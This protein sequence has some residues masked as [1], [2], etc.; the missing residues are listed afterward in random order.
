[1]PHDVRIHEAKLSAED[2]RTMQGDL[3]SSALEYAPW[4][5]VSITNGMTFA[6]IKLATMG[7]LRQVKASSLKTARDFLT[8][9]EEWAA[10]FVGS[11]FWFLHPDSDASYKKVSCRMIDGLLE[12]PATGSANCALGSFLALR[13]AGGNGDSHL[14]LES[15]QGY[16]MGRPSDITVSVGVQQ[17]RIKEVLL[18]GSAVRVMDG[19]LLP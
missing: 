11:L 10:T 12:D 8:L 14:K 15:M 13:E 9:D 2:L 18:E 6:L 5:I 1:M 7:E 19:T 17:G 3:R 4:P 16:D